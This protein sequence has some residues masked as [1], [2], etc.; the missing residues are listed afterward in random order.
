MMTGTMMWATMRATIETGEAPRRL[1]SRLPQWARSA[2]TRLAVSALVLLA[3]SLLASVLALNQ[4]LT[5]RTGERVDRE[6][7]QEVS[8][9]R[10]LVAQGQ[11][12]RTGRP[13][14]NDIEGV[15]EV[16]L[17][18]NVPTEGEAFFTFIEGAPFRASSTSIQEQAILAEIEGLGSVEQTTRGEVEADADEVRYLA[19][20]IRIG[21]GTRGV[22]A[23]TIS[24]GGELDE[25]NDAVR[26]AGGVSIIVFLIAGLV[27][28]ISAGRILAPVRVLTEA[29][30][31]ITESD[32]TRRIEVEGN[33]EIAELARTFNQMLDRLEAA[34]SSQRRF[35]SDAGH[36]LRTPITIVRGHLE[37]MGEDPEERRETIALVTDELDRMARLVDDLLLLERAQRPDFLRTEVM[38]LDEFAAELL[39]KATAIAPRD[40]RLGRGGQGTVE[41]DRQRLTQALVNLAQNAADHTADGDEI[42]I[43]AQ[44]RNGEAR[45]WVRD[46]GPGID[47]SDQQ[48][49]FERFQRG[50]RAARG[51]GSGLGLAI[52]SAIAEA[53]GGRVELSSRPGGG[54]TFTIVL[55]ATHGGET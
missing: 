14:G 15:F 19:V 1:R 37:V 16:F 49:V 25:V 47:Y 11:D 5:A 10:R 12:P 36:E 21:A 30:R 23:V 53:H 50:D 39:A 41:A 18:R 55:P 24:L 33:D 32:L 44:R 4:I 3:V 13:F 6:L 9:F 51:E 46:T 38:E 2:R 20:P 43:G 7:E 27:V 26:V 48:R 40:W 34:F 31:S 28:F 52:V 29:A 54:S 8:E 17:S 35:L 45:F 22:F 42:E